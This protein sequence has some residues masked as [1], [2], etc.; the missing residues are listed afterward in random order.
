M[1]QAEHLQVDRLLALL[2]F[3]SCRFDRSRFVHRDSSIAP[4]DPGKD[5]GHPIILFLTNR[6]EF[7]V[8]APG[9]MDSDSAHARHHLS[10]HIVQIVGSCQAFDHGAWCFDLANKI[11]WT[12]G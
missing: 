12:D 11:P 6:I 10:H 5:R 1:A 9:A 2:E 7:M 4:S 8:V 3:L